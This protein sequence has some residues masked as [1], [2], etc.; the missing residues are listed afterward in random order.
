MANFDQLVTEYC[1]ACRADETQLSVEEI[2][3]LLTHL[4]DWQL[5]EHDQIKKLQKNYRFPD[6]V[7]ALAFT[8]KIG[9]MAEEQGHHPDIVTAWG[10]VELSWYTH[11]IKGLHRNDFRC[12]ARSDQ[13]YT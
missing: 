2:H 8:N 7:S 3:D 13:L 6:F 9:A 4:S 1:K 11:K 10:R 12:A 5:V